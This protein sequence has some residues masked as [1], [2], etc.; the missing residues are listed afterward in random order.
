[1]G[2]GR[3]ATRAAQ[4]R[5]SPPVA[6]ADGRPAA[7]ARRRRRRR[8]Q[9]RRRW[10][11]RSRRAARDA[12]LDA[13]RGR[14]RCC[15]RV[16]ARGRRRVRLRARDARAR[17]GA[18]AAWLPRRAVLLC[19]DPVDGRLRRRR[20]AL[21]RGQ[22]VHRALP[23]RRSPLRRRGALGHLGA[24]GRRR[25]A[26]PR[27]R[28]EGAR[29]SR[30]TKTRRA[31]WRS[32]WRRSRSS[33]RWAPP[34]GGSPR[35]AGTPW[36]VCTGRSPR[37]PRW[38][39][40]RGATTPRGRPTASSP[41]STSRW[42]PGRPPHTRRLRRR[43]RERLH[44]Q[45]GRRRRQRQLRRRQ[46][47]RRRRRRRRRLRPL[48]LRGRPPTPPTTPPPRSDAVAKPQLI[49][50]PNIEI[51]KFGFLERFTKPYSYVFDPFHRVLSWSS[52]WHRV[53][54]RLLFP[55][56]AIRWYSYSTAPLGEV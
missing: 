17:R 20:A 6:R 47:Q 36:M 51:G 5:E 33:W 40:A 7:G 43:V 37:S 4:R 25:G 22:G 50:T 10:G 29:R 21:A 2:R 1:M 14:A 9:R 18:S 38:A 49:S 52:A 15:W 46:R 35:T 24:R 13:P 28:A 34:W 48:I 12:G 56:P 19:G 44:P 16:R 42:A 23:A 3:C 45:R 53:R 11:A 8:R 31:R 26:R 30:A 55:I 39:T 41:S 27:A 32:R 54:S